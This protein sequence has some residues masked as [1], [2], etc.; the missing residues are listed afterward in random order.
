MI[1]IRLYEKSEKNA[2]ISFTFKLMK[3][4]IKSRLLT[5]KK[6]EIDGFNKR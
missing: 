5:T 6:G 4:G 1:K 2:A 3:E